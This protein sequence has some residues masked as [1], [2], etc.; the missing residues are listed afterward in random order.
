MEKKKAA[1]FFTGCRLKILLVLR[2][3]C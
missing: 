3:I 2:I 1:A